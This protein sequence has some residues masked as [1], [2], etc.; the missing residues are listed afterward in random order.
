MPVEY[1]MQQ[2]GTQPDPLTGRPDYEE[3]PVWAHNPTGPGFDPQPPHMEV[4][5][6]HLAMS[7]RLRLTFLSGRCRGSGGGRGGA[8]MWFGVVVCGVFRVL[9][10]GGRAV[11][12]VAVRAGGVAAWL[13]RRGGERRECL[14]APASGSGREPGGGAF[15]VVGL[16]GGVGGQDALVAGGEQAG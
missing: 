8:V 16:P 13:W 6:F 2:D 10:P 5:T 4:F 9:T 12:G 3:G 7:S 14:A 11:D 1:A 15:L